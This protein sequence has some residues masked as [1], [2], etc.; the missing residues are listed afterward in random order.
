VSGTIGE[1]IAVKALKAGAQDYVLKGDLTRL[2][3]AIE[4]PFEPAELLAVIARLTG[5]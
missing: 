5:L 4:K 3:A 1:A 2:P